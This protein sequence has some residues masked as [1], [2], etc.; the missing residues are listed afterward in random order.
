MR[1]YG[2]IGGAIVVVCFIAVISVYLHARRPAAASPPGFQHKLLSYNLSPYDL[3]PDAVEPL[4][5]GALGG[6]CKAAEILTRYYFEVRVDFYGGLRWVRV[7]AKNCPD[8][9]A[10]MELGM[11]LVHYK[12]DPKAAAEVADLV[13]QI[14]KINRQQAAELQSELDGSRL[15]WPLHVPGSGL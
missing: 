4:K 15:E 10:K 12:N 9:R 1:K 5:A 13:V 7:A 11:I 2:L 6:N 8:A 14:Q 3:P